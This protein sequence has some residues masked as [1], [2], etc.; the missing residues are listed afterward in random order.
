VTQR[1]IETYGIM[2]TM[3]NDDLAATHDFWYLC[4]NRHAGTWNARVPDCRQF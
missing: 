3:T 1:R 4:H 2:R